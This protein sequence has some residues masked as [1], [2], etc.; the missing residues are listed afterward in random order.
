MVS[1]S[2]EIEQ[3]NAIGCHM[4]NL[5]SQD[6]RALNL[7]QIM[8]KLGRRGLLG[9]LEYMSNQGFSGIWNKANKYLQLGRVHNIN[10]S[11]DKRHSV[12]TWRG[13]L[14]SQIKTDSV[15]RKY[16]EI[17][18]PMPERTFH[19]ILTH[20]DLDFRE[21]TFVDFGAGKGKVLLMAAN[22]PFEKI[23]GV[24]FASNLH[25]IAENNIA[26]YKNKQQ[27]CFNVEIILE[28]ACDLVLPDGKCLF[29]LFAPFKGPVLEKVLEN[30]R[31]SMVENPRPSTICFVD[32]DL[33]YSLIGQVADT[34][35][36]WG[37]F[38]RHIIGDIPSDSGAV[39]PMD[40]TFWSSS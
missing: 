30:I 7:S 25:R 27:Q 40:G 34:V 24:E 5:G 38:T 17:Y 20:F 32:D 9:S 13:V 4:S 15:N 28:D 3:R 23:V 14:A 36:A 29:F 31:Q 33:S 26:N 10:R 18:T 37:L 12:D 16:S 2:N 22:Y 19:Y 39:M 6:K 1:F 35:E 11:Y 21:Y 8:R